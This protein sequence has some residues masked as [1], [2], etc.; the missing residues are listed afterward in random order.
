LLTPLPISKLQYHPCGYIP[1]NVTLHD[2]CVTT[3]NATF[4][5]NFVYL[6]LPVDTSACFAEVV[7][8]VDTSY[9]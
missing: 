8:R 6:T 1:E 3:S 7:K 5:A 2:H 9:R 4:L